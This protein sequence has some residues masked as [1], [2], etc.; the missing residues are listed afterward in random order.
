[1]LAISCLN[2]LYYFTI[3]LINLNHGRAIQHP[4]PVGA[5]PVKIHWHRA[6]GYLQ[7]WVAHQPGK[8]R[9]VLR[10]L[11]LPIELKR[12]LTFCRAGT[13]PQFSGF[14]LWI[15]GSRRSRALLIL[16]SSLSGSQFCFIILLILANYSSSIPQAF[17]YIG[18]GLNRALGLCTA[19]PRAVPALTFWAFKDW[20][21]SSRFLIYSQSS[22]LSLCAKELS[23]RFAVIK[24]IISVKLNND[25]KPGPLLREFHEGV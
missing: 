13:G 22:R 10:P 1:M 23:K 17:V 7:V 11:R 16:P 4:Q 2:L 15:S 20:N 19:G 12:A 25:L 14:E 5:P 3:F 18:P 9:N 21:L 6:R 8:S 24:D